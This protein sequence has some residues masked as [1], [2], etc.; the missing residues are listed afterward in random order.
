MQFCSF[1]SR[2]IYQGG[3]STKN[4]CSFAV[5]IVGLYIKAVFLQKMNAV[6]QFL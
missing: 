2:F 6:L 4:E 5:F 3:F 1:Y